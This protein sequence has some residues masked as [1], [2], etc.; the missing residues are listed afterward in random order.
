MLVYDP[1]ECSNC[2]HVFCKQCINDWKAKGKE[3]CPLCKASLTIS[4]L[5]RILKKF[6]EQTLISG[7]PAS[8]CDQH[9]TEMSY[10]KLINH[11]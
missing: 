5:N 1:V 9:T 11:L 4:P 2:D 8:D 7:C 6:L 10:D 3:E